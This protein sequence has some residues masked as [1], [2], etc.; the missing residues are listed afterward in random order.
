MTSKSVNMLLLGI[1]GQGM[2][3]RF[4][5]HFNFWTYACE[6]NF[7]VSTTSYKAFFYVDAKSIL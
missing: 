6:E 4:K 3:F 5:W 7:S 1:F 2:L